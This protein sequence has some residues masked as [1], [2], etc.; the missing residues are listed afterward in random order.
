MCTLDL[1]LPDQ[2]LSLAFEL[3][4]RKAEAG[5]LVARMTAEA[6]ADVV[7]ED[8]DSALA[9]IAN[10]IVG[11]LHNGLSERGVVCRIGLPTID[12]RTALRTPTDDGR[13]TTVQ[14]RCENGRPELWLHVVAEPDEPST[15]QQPAA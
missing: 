9:E 8:R 10:M 5:D 13:S 2:S 1:A 12:M 3:S 15:D 11:R 4:V 6:V 14:F 7:E